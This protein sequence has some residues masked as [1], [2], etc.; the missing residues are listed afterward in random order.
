MSIVKLEKLKNLL[1]K[2][3]NVHILSLWTEKN[4]C[5]FLYTID[6]MGNFFFLNVKPYDIFLDESIT[7]PWD[8]YHIKF[9]YETESVFSLRY[10]EQFISTFQRYINKIVYHV[11]D[12]LILNQNNIYKVIE[13]THLTGYRVVFHKFDLDW[14]YENKLNFTSEILALND[15]LNCKV[16]YFK[17]NDII[18]TE[19]I[20]TKVPESFLETTI[21]TLEDIQDNVEKYKKLFINVK[22]FEGTI[23]KE[24][25]ELD[26]F[27]NHRT[28][29]DTKRIELKRRKK[30]KI[31]NLTSIMKDIIKN[32]QN[33]YLDY[34]H[35]TNL[36][37]YYKSELDK[38]YISLESSFIE[39]HK[40][41]NSYS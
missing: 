8:R 7:L 10:Y 40:K 3:F 27:S 4:R 22:I 36:Y 38:K 26:D 15:E 14:L 19:D 32:L 34:L 35:K 39:F 31:K 17:E 25:K 23:T 16:N 37:I 28:M 5:C 33:N 13:K 29:S 1:Q 24:L 20:T 9:V 12:H 18:Q 30:Q 6:N 21:Q 11:D 41:W 2:Q